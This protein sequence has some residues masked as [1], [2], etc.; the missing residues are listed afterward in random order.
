M[1]IHVN[2]LGIQS[3]K[4][5]AIACICKDSCYII[6]FSNARKAGAC[7]VLMAETIFIQDEST[8]WYNIE[9]ETYSAKWFAC[10][11][12]CKAN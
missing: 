11:N 4:S 1:K 8:F 3:I 12:T 10:D 5:L 9:F 6:L 2:A 7:T